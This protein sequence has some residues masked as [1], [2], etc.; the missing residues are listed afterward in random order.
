MRKHAIHWFVMVLLLI[1]WHEARAA[2]L[3]TIANGSAPMGSVQRDSTTVWTDDDLTAAGGL[4]NGALITIKGYPDSLGRR[5]NATVSGLTSTYFEMS[6]AW[7]YGDLSNAKIVLR[8]KEINYAADGL[9]NYYIT[10]TDSLYTF[11]T[12]TEYPSGTQNF[13]G[14][15]VYNFDGIITTITPHAF[16]SF[17]DSTRAI[18]CTEDVYAQITNAS[19][20]LF[21]VDDTLR[22][23]YAVGDTMIIKFAGDYYLNFNCS[24]QGNNGE[25]WSFS[26]IDATAPEAN[27]VIGS[28]SYR[29]TSNN[30]IGNATVQWYLVDAEVDDKIIVGIR[31]N[32]DSD[33]ATV[34]SGTWFIR[35]Q[36]D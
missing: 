27:V 9:A 35:Y 22:V 8:C 10:T 18:E 20:N 7:P 15:D 28:S 11:M 34:T 4:F 25:S 13:S 6:S 31:N 5:H 14:A 36:E 29:Y 12:S 17:S 16:I 26:F 19:D 23:S 30:D 24:F 33:N 2:D 3:Q 21:A 32:T 1:C